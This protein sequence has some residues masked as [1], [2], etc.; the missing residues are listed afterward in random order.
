MI[1]A[2]I[3]LNTRSDVTNFMVALQQSSD[4]YIVEDKTGRYRANPRSVLGLLYM[5]S[6]HGDD[7][8]LVNTTNDGNF[9]G[10]VDKYR[11]E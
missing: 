11:H 5:A 7:L 1:R 2:Q 6:E 8:Y 10:F 4:E 3:Q 9:P